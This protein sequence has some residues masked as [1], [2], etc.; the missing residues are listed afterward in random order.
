MLEHSP[1]AYNKQ[2]ALQGSQCFGPQ[3][4]P[5]KKIPWGKKRGEVPPSFPI[6]REDVPLLL[7]G[8]WKAEVVTPAA[9]EA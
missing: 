8:G 5:G 4:S 3:G 9:H 7:C 6:V 2:A 1:Q